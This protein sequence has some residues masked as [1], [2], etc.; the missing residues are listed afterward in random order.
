VPAIASV[1]LA[2][3]LMAGTGP[4]PGAQPCFGLFTPAEFDDEVADLDIICTAECE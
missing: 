1:I 4:A 3:R 2:K